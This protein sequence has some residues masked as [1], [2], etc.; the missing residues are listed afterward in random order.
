MNFY[1]HTMIGLV[2]GA[3]LL[4]SALA[5]DSGDSSGDSGGGTSTSSNSATDTSS[6]STGSPSSG[7]VFGSGAA[8]S[9]GPGVLTP[10]TGTD[11]GTETPSTGGNIFAPAPVSGNITPETTN[12]A[13]TENSGVT[14]NVPTQA[15]PA[16]TVSGAF[17][18]TPQTLQAGTG[19]FAKKPYKLTL[20]VSQ[21]YDD[22]VF[23]ASDDHAPTQVV[24]P[25]TPDETITYYQTIPGR[26]AV[27]PRFDSGGN[28]ISPGIPAVPAQKIKHHVTIP[29]TPDQVVDLGEDPLSERIGSLVT[30]TSLAF[31][32]NFAS[33]RTLFS[34][35]LNGGVDYYWDRPQ[36]KEQYNGAV[37]FV[38]THAVTPRMRLNMYLD[39]VYQNNPDFSRVNTA[40]RNAQGSYY[41]TNFR[42]DLD[43]QWNA[44]FSTETSY[45]FNGTY[46]ESEAQKGQNLTQNIVSNDF[47]LTLSPRTTA[48][49]SYRY[50]M[51]ERQDATQNATNQFVLGGFDYNFSAR[52]ASTL[53]VGEQLQSLDVGRNTSS[54]YIETS[55][56]YI[57]GK[58]STIT[59]TNRYGLDAP[60]ASTKDIN[61]YVTGLSVSHVLT[62]RTSL[63][64]GL[65]WTHR[66]TNYLDPAVTALREDYLS[67][68][69]T[70]QYVYSENWSFNINYNYNQLLSSTDFTSYHRNQI[71]FGFEYDF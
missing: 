4:S 31:S 17:G 49:I 60:D 46:F 23:S 32:W 14:S 48:V 53:R 39:S 59:W 28:I 69:L 62:A 37:K 1:R 65:N 10:G 52:M 30:S 13:T 33:P 21:G 50:G 20:S 47:R 51:D 7:S 61:S 15:P 45:S 34:L 5:Q 19:Q 68:N 18:T 56:R 57:Y 42:I 12:Q 2:I 26:P 70:F 44:R 55:L 35:Q 27:P 9:S 66:E 29:G 63:G 6:G 22:N 71:F 64:V 24:I 3:G 36:K 16:V 8:N 11:Q 40:T 25:G 43:Y 54:P 41:D 38:F 58:G 67:A